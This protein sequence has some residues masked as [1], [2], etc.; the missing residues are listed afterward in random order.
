LNVLALVHNVEMKTAPPS[1][2]RVYRK[3]SPRLAQSLENLTPEQIE[4][5]IK[6]ASKLLALRAMREKGKIDKPPSM[7]SARNE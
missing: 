4:R 5:A 6:I 1:S 2:L 3:P 7:P